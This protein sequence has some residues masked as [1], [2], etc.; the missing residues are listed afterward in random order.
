M[1]PMYVICF[2]WEGERWQTREGI[3]QPTDPAYI[4]HLQRAGNTPKELPSR[5]VN[6]LF[7]GVSRF[8]SQE[9]KFV[10]FTNEPMEV[11]PGV[12]IRPFNLVTTKGVLP[13]L[14]MFSEEAG[15]FGHQVLC[16]DLDVVVVGDMEPLMKYDGLFCARSKFLPREQHK[17]DGDIMSF[18]AGPEAEAIFWTP[19]IADVPGNVQFTQGRERYWVRKVAGD[20]ADRWDVQAPSAVLSVKWHMRGRQEVPKGAVIISCHGFPRPHQVKDEWIKKY[21]S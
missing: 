7:R 11:D 12:E 18:R 5:Y 16:L 4:R 19:F 14:H 21:W 15:L 6:N 10:C 3:E 17:L 13:R 20:I 9:F 8:A 2:Y 1:K